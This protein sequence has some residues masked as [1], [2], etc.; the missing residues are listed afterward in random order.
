MRFK[1]LSHV[2]SGRH[3][4][5]VQH[6]IDRSTIRQER[7]VF[8]R[9]DTGNN[10]LVTVTACHLVTD[11]N[12]ALGSNIDF[13]FL[14]CAKIVTVTVFK[15]VNGLIFHPFNTVESG[16]VGTDD[17]VNRVFDLAIVHTIGIVLVRKFCNRRSRNLAVRGNKNHI[18]AGR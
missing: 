10:T 18:I 5:R 13:H 11:L 2:H 3:A 14:D 9:N 17:L 8:H 16:L 6:D 15:S 7:H 12:L 1:H 4:E